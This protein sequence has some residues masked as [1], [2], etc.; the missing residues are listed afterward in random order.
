MSFEE[1]GMAVPCL[2]MANEYGYKDLYARQPYQPQMFKTHFWYH[3]TPKGAGMYIV[4]ARYG[5]N[6]RALVL[7]VCV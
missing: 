3:F 4:V 7:K 1:I 5:R 6:H 2:E